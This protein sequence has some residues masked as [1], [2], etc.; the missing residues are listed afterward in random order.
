MAEQNWM[1][2]VQW[3]RVVA[4]TVLLGIP[5]VACVGIYWHGASERVVVERFHKLFYHK[6]GTWTRNQWL[7]VQT[8]QNP[9]DVWITQE[10]IVEVKPDVIIE[11]GTA[12]G[13]SAALWAMILEEV[14][15][16]GR[17][18][19]IDIEDQIADARKLRIF[20]EKVDFLLGSSTDP[21]IVEEITG[22]V[23]G[24][25]VLV[26]LD[27]DHHMG[28]VLEEMKHYAPLVSVGSYLI[29][30]DSNINGHP[31]MNEHGPG[32]ME[33]IDAFLATHDGF[34]PDGTRERLLFTMHPRGY[35]KRVK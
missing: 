19:T 18:I 27:S 28:H 24:K 7:G 9:N 29:V 10:I 11:A 14:N 23:D 15:P 34:E 16:L 1:G 4:L 2:R 3:W 17:V 30:Q 35:L 13:G 8:S 20:Q 6:T 5:V 33:A 26:I 31:V 21:K 32:P 12:G 25:R 22:R